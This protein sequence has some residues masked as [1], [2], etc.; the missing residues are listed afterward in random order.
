MAQEHGKRKKPMGK[1]KKRGIYAACL[2]IGLGIGFAGGF[3]LQKELKKPKTESSSEKTSNSSPANTSA[4]TPASS[5]TAPSTLPAQTAPAATAPAPGPVAS[6]PAQAMR[7]YLTSK[8][9][10]GSSMSFA[11]VSTSRVDPTWK[12]DKGTRSSGQTMYFLLHNVTGGW[13]VLDYGPSLTAEQMRV[14]GAP[15]DLP[16]A[17]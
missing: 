13:S 12:I 10:D 7:E 1:W 6:T 9:I 8:G 2:I 11:V 16:P 15:A 4:T 14:D 17:G 3:Y 5:S